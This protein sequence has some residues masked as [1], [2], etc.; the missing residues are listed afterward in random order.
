LEEYSSRLLLSLG[1]L[2][3][4]KV[5]DYST[6]TQSCAGRETYKGAE[7]IPHLEREV[8]IFRTIYPLRFGQRSSS[9]CCAGNYKSQK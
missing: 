7:S 4:S 2:A 1:W 8:D 9:F 5:K 3:K 6:K